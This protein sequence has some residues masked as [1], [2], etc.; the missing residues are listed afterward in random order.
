MFVAA[1]YED[2]GPVVTA[3]TLSPQTVEDDLHVLQQPYRCRRGIAR[4]PAR[5]FG[6]LEKPE[7]G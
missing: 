7:V 5:S 3:V 6:V 1:V 2:L 4:I